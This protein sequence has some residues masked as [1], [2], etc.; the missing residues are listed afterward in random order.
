[1]EVEKGEHYAASQ[2]FFEYGCAEEE[3]LRDVLQCYG[4]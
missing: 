3:C 1:M 4:P 2:F